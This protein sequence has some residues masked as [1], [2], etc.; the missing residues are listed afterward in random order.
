MI[1]G[2]TGGTKFIGQKLVFHLLEKGN[3]VRDLSRSGK[4]KLS[5]NIEVYK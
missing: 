5:K 1:I 4:N 3:Y 2:V